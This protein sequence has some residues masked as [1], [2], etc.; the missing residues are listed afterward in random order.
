[1]SVT[2]KTIA[3]DVLA[4]KALEIMQANNISQILVVDGENYKG[5]VHLHNLIKEGIL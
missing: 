4:V 5:I 3:S 1:M 2:P